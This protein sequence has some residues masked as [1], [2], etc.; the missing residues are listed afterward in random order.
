MNS[1][2][3]FPGMGVNAPTPVA[4][5]VSPPLVTNTFC[6]VTL[7][8]INGAGGGLKLV[9]VAVVAPFRTPST[10]PR[11]RPNGS[12]KAYGLMIVTRSRGGSWEQQA[13]RRTLVQLFERLKQPGAHHRKERANQK[14][15]EICLF[16]PLLQACFWA[17]RNQ[18][19]PH[20][21]VVRLFQ[22]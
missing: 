17:V 4:T 6:V 11:V 18:R 16:P 3:G 13:T 8:T 21:P 19:Q 7:S 10:V 12:F 15:G 22:A 14:L 5:R 9:I 2:G 20:L 1:P